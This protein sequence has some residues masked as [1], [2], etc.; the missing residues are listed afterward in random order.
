MKS[1]LLAVFALVGV[2]AFAVNLQRPS[3]LRSADPAQLD[4]Y[5]SATT[6][7]L[8]KHPGDHHLKKHLS[9]LKNLRSDIQ[10]AQQ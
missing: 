10:E 4:S 1:T 5:I 9:E 7:Q 8:A 2:A 6:E 3:F